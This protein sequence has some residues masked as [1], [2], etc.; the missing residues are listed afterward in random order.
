MTDEKPRK[1]IILPSD[2]RGQIDPPTIVPTLESLLS[3]ALSIIGG[4]LAQYRSKSKRGVTLDL[5]EARAVQGY[6]EALIKLSREDRE[7]ARSEDLTNLSDEELR[8]LAT[9]VLKID[10]SSIQNSNEE[11]DE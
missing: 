11:S 1:R 6:M 3:D 9:E 5:K 7:R 8:Q 10:N 4:E 2:K